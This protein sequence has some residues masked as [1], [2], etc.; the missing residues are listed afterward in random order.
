MDSWEP[1]PVSIFQETT[2]TPLRVHVQPGTD[3]RPDDEESMGLV[4][5]DVVGVDAVH[6]PSLPLARWEEIRV[7]FRQENDT[8]SRSD[9]AAYPD[10]V[11]IEAEEGAGAQEDMEEVVDR[12]DRTPSMSKPFY[13]FAAGKCLAQK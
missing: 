5:G 12:L 9:L 8:N 13:R 1:F 11:L 7:L 3:C 4:A 10:K 6:Q 2:G